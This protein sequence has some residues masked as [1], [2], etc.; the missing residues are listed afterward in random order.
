MADDPTQKPNEG[1]PWYGELAEDTAPELKDWITNKAFADP[2][3][4]LQSGFNTEK[5]IGLEKAGRTVVMPK[6]E[7]DTEGLAAFRTKLGVP[8]SPD[9]YEL[10]VPE[11]GSEDFS[12]VASTWF[13]EA[14][15]P[16]AAAVSIAEKWNTHIN[17]L[18][19]AQQDEAKLKAEQQLN[20]L[21]TEWGDAY[22]KNAE[23]GRRGFQAYGSKAGLDENDL[24]ALESTIGTA[25]MLK[26]FHSLGESMSESDF[27]EGEHKDF[28][29]TPDEA[30]TRLDE[31]RKKRVAG[32]LT[33]KEFLALEDKYGPMIKAT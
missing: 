2:I 29:M 13:H 20:A 11:G 10:P 5:L 26:L 32:D 17:E 12:K 7:N 23:F 4:A 25:K 21:K 28:S 1:E 8:D 31:A 22:G 14:G 9:G 24:K 15:V 27:T 30:Q 33:E 3:T 19:T 16:K 6:D 18:V